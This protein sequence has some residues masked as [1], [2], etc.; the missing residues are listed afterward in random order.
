MLNRCQCCMGG[1]RSRFRRVWLTRRSLEY[2]GAN[3]ELVEK[4]RFFLIISNKGRRKRIHTTT[5]IP[6][7][8]A[9]EPYRR[10]LGENRRAA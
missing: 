8:I 9:K 2:I 5:R 3:T 7:S 6:E 4:L 1:W 10:L